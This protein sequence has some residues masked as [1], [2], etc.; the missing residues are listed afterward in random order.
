RSHKQKLPDCHMSVKNGQLV[1]TVS[2][3]G[4]ITLESVAFRQNADFFE[5]IFGIRP[6]LKQKRRLS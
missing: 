3:E 6:I 1:V 4:D 5:E 2:Y